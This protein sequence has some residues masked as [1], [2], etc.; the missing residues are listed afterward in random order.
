LM[1]TLSMNVLPSRSGRSVGSR[2]REGQVA[3]LRG[4]RKRKSPAP[5]I[6]N[7]LYI[8]H[9]RGNCR[10]RRIARRACRRAATLGRQALSP[11]SQGA[12]ST[13]CVRPSAR[14]PRGLCM[15]Q[16]LSILLFSVD[17]DHHYSRRLFCLPRA[18]SD[19]ALNFLRDAMRKPRPTFGR[20]EDGR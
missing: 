17:G 7:T 19:G 13:Q 14:R 12:S 15:L 20:R 2:M 10:Y 6:R 16:G 5:Q 9:P 18:T 1:V 3:P 4:R 11:A 8:K